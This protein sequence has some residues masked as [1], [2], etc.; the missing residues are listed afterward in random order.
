MYVFVKD[1]RELTKQTRRLI[2]ENLM[3][4]TPFSK[5]YTHAI[6]R[7]RFQVDPLLH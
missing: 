2:E 3:I 5:L 4:K 7:A 1:E 6:V